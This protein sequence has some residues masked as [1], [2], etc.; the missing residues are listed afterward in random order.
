MCGPTC[1]EDIGVLAPPSHA[2]SFQFEVPVLLNWIAGEESEE[3]ES[4]APASGETDHEPR[5]IPC[6]AVL[7][8]KEAEVLKENG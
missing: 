8:F 6:E 4:N 3:K 2:L 5:K 1:E 7:H